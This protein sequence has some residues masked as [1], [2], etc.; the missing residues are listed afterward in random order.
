MGVYTG[1]ISNLA[2]TGHAPTSTEM[3]TLHDALLALTDPQTSYSPG[4]TGITLGNG[5]IVGSYTQVGKFVTFRW[6]LT[7]GSTTSVTGAVS[8]GMPPPA[9]L[10][11]GWAGSAFLFDSSIAANRQSG[12]LNGGTTA[13]QVFSSAGQVAAAVPFTWAVGDVIKG[14]GT[15]EAA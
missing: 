14:S 2:I 9:G 10:D 13:N 7:F 1:T 5:T 6:T 12:T 15:Y 4:L 8:I 11:A 3:D